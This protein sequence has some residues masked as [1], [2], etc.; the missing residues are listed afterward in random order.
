MK[1]IFQAGLHKKI[2][3]KYLKEPELVQAL[4]CMMPTFIT[5]ETR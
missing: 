2:K 1:S 4:F 3:E 5:T